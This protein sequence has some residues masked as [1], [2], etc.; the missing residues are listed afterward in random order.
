MTRIVTTTYRYKPPK[1]RKAVAIAGP[2]VVRKRSKA[3]AAVLPPDEP[4][5]AA[6]SPA[7]DDSLTRAGSCREIGDRHLH[8][9]QAGE[10]GT[11]RAGRGAGARR[12]RGGRRDAGMARAREMG[13]RASQMSDGTDKA[14]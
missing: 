7:N 2:A 1:K 10:A 11:H 8:Q 14:A 13:P 12:P 6:P 3:D 5:P 9:P 4:E